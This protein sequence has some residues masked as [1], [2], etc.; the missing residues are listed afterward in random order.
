MTSIRLTESGGTAQLR[1]GDTVELCLPEVR[2][3]GY[4]WRWVLPDAVRV[5]ADEHVRPGDEGAPGAGG[6]RLLAL[7]V[8]EAGRHL[9]RAELARPWD[10]R[11]R[12]SV[13][14]VLAVT[15][16]NE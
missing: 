16:P 8:V 3:S 14:F 7:D 9:L 15:A 12:R 6:A 2:S 10:T 1:V 5:V 13:T 11:P 4:R